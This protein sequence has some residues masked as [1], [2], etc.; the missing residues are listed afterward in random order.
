MSLPAIDF[1]A[2][3]NGTEQK[4]RELANCVTEEFKKHG[5]TR[6]TNHGLTA[7]TITK[8]YEWSEKFFKLS[9]AEKAAIAN[10][11]DANPQ[12]GYSYVGSEATSKVNKRDQRGEFQICEDDDV[13][14]ELVDAKEHF[15]YTR[16]GDEYATPWPSD[17]SIPG[18]HD[19]ME[20]TFLPECMTLARDVLTAIE[21]G[22][23][24]PV[25][26]FTSC[27]SSYVDELRIQHYPPLA[28]SKLAAGKIKRCHAHTDF[29]FLTLLFQDATGGLEV[30]DRV[31]GGWLPVVPTGDPTEVGVYVGDTLVHK[32]N[33]HLRAAVHHV[34]APVSLKNREDGV[35]PERFTIALFAKADRHAVVGPMP[36]FVTS[37]TPQ[38]FPSLTALE[39]H[40][41]RV[42]Q[43]YDARPKEIGALEGGPGEGEG[44]EG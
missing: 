31:N 38:R 44:L 26:T 25:G 34:V 7:E 24:V 27:M 40:N 1:S 12:R 22:L 37:E 14:Q 9:E 5:A 32:T 33:G 8:A 15:D 41:K 4:R 19:W 11:R 18:F 6:L 17:A 35:M 42:G 20:G 43:L 2:F 3:R 13:D 28:V 23:D 10:V 16:D 29:G 30:E 36:K 21:L 39:L